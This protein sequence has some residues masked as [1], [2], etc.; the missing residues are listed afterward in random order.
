VRILLINYEFPPLGGGAGNATANIA[1][2]LVGLGDCV[3]ILTS[4]YR[5]VPWHET[6]GGYCVR[7]CPAIRRRLDRSTPVEMISFIL[8]GIFPA[9]ATGRTWQPNVVCAFFG[10]PSGPLAYLLKRVYGVPYIVSLRGGDV[11]GFLPADLGSY[12]RLTRSITRA[13]WQSA[14][15]VVA[16]SAGLGRL[17][18]DTWPEAPLVVIPNGVDTD[19]FTPDI[20][21]DKN[22]WLRLLY[23]GRL[24]RS[25]GVDLVLAA[26]RDLPRVR[27]RIVGDGPERGSL[28]LLARDLGIEDRVEFSGW[29]GRPA[30][31]QQY[32]WAN[33][34]VLLSEEEGMSNVLLEAMASGLPI[35]A[36][37][38]YANREL[39][40]PGENGRLVSSRNRSE[41][42]QAIRQLLDDA[43]LR[44]RWGANGRRAAL[45]RNW[46]SVAT[47]YHNV[48]SRVAA[49]L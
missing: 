25:K 11:P 36:S 4:H 14:G 18:Q 12:H 40:E 47:E 20:S 48:L 26:L 16:N 22:E 15:A 28:T 33:A 30:L 44:R 2:G 13:I 5:G 23:V 7:R 10:L 42:A 21:Q 17:A 27:L 39:V 31:P 41:L 46:A 1:R 38:N 34:F 9:I 19:L 49:R 24:V 35:I 6:Q 3:Q 45:A 37:D 43:D 8:G 32:H 29:L